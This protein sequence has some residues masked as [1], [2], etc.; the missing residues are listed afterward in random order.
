MPFSDPMNQTGNAPQLVLFTTNLAPFNSKQSQSKHL[1]DK[2]VGSCGKQEVTFSASKSTAGG[3]SLSKPYHEIENFPTG[4]IMKRKPI[5]HQKFAVWGR[6]LSTKGCIT[7]P[8]LK[9]SDRTA[10]TL[11]SP[12]RSS[13]SAIHMSSLPPQPPLTRY[14]T[15]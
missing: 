11:T 3:P 1:S 6:T 5:S 9:S 7:L 2:S 15:T 12:L 13:D 8:C 10:C 4:I 14:L